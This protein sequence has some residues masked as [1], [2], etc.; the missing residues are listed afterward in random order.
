MINQSGVCHEA[1]AQ[2]ARARG[3]AGARRAADY[4]KRTNSA[5]SIMTF[6]A[7]LPFLGISRMVAVICLVPRGAL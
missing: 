3:G 5:V 7:E 6:H 2:G 4:L 1:R